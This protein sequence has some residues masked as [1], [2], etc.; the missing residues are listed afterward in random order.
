MEDHCWVGYFIGYPFNS[1]AFLVYDPSRALR[2]EDWV[3]IPAE[4]TCVSSPFFTARTVHFFAISSA[5]TVR[6]FAFLHGAHS[7]FLRHFFGMHNAF[8]RLGGC[9]NG[10]TA[11]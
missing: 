7:A 8:L 3:R 1:K 4:S 11:I 9:A 2:R 6:F 10:L 5:C